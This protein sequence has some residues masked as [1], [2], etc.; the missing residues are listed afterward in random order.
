MGRAEA[1]AALSVG[2]A[3]QFG[4]TSK[5]AAYLGG[6]PAVRGATPPQG[7]RSPFAL[8]VAEQRKLDLGQVGVRVAAGDPEASDDTAE[9]ADHGVGDDP[10]PGVGPGRDPGAATPSASGECSSAFHSHHT[11]SRPP[12]TR[13][14]QPCWSGPSGPI[15]REGIEGTGRV[16]GFGR[17]A[18]PVSCWRSSTGRARGP[19]GTAAATDPA[20]EDGMDPADRAVV[21]SE[22]PRGLLLNLKSFRAEARSR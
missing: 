6:E 7:Q 20:V 17:P 18:I 14:F 5:K 8:Q 9:Q 12:A 2:H 22:V 3:A 13:G 15:S 10:Q 1:H 19:T 16:S 21:E 11:G 4:M